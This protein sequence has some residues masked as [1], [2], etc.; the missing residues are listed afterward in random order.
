M[1]GKAVPI[2]S[3][4]PPHGAAYVDL[5]QAYPHDTDKAKKNV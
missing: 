2:G 3:F 1:Y 5:T 4:Y